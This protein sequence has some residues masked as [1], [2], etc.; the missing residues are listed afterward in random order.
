MKRKSPSPVA[1]P[2]VKRKYTKGGTSQ[3]ALRGYRRK[4]V[5]KSAEFV[6]SDSNDDEDRDP[7]MQDAPPGADIRDRARKTEAS[8]S[9]A[10]LASDMHDNEDETTEAD[11]KPAVLST[12]AQTSKQSSSHDTPKR[13][14]TIVTPDDT[15][16]KTQPAQTPR[17]SKK[18][19]LSSH[20][21]PRTRATKPASPAHLASL[22]PPP[23]SWSTISNSPSP[24]STPSPS[25]SPHHSSPTTTTTNP[26]FPTTTPFLPSTTNRPPFPPLPPLPP[27]RRAPFRRGAHIALENVRDDHRAHPTETLAELLAQL[28]GNRPQVEDWE[29]RTVVRGGGW[30]YGALRA[31]GQGEGEGEEEDDMMG[32]V[33][34]G[35]GER[36]DDGEK[37]GKAGVDIEALVARLEEWFEGEWERMGWSRERGR[38]DEGGSGSGSE[39]SDI[40]AND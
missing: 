9:E 2:R 6:V 34:G 33:G 8:D 19:P 10:A 16:D 26:T 5:P 4:S 21:Q 17:R 15:H 18:S 22:S 12:R 30:V 24:S 38:E 20:P 27:P 11:D 40:W 3:R 23:R 37:T 31:V 36:E 35:G 25:L 13:N 28:E 14:T 1:D 29:R 7:E 39:A 32:D